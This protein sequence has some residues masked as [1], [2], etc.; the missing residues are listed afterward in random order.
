MHT[1]TLVLAVAAIS[2]LGMT[3]CLGTAL[4]LALRQ[5]NGPPQP[6][7][8]RNAMVFT[9]CIC[10]R[11]SE[12]AKS[13]LIPL[14]APEKALAVRE[15]PAVGG[16]PLAEYICSYCESS[17]CFAIDRSRPEWVGVN[18]YTPQT[19]TTRC[20][21]CGKPLVGP[22]PAKVAC[23]E[24]NRGIPDL[25]RDCG[26]ICAFCGAICCVACCLGMT[27]KRTS[28]GSLMCPRCRRQPVSR[29]FYP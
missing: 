18:L 24:H 13:A 16:R 5:Q 28:D 8:R 14:S 15:I 27:R 9:C 23:G 12:V 26:L 25:P 11:Q 1:P 20:Q 10:R 7:V 3:L 6:V 29:V 21:E 19:K 2:G 22:A 4:W 17:H